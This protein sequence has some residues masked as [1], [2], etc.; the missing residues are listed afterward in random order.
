MTPIYQGGVTE[1]LD[2]S[3]TTHPSSLFVFPRPVIYSSEQKLLVE[4]LH[5]VS[6]VCG[7]WWSEESCIYDSNTNTTRPS[8]AHTM[9][10]SISPCLH[11]WGP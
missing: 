7:S 8:M 1:R 9:E 5:A 6:L 2:C 3:T 4:L 10:E 11:G